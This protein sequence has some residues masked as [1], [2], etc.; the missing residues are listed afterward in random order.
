MVKIGQAKILFDLQYALGNG[1]YILVD[2]DSIHEIYRCD[3]G[4]YYLLAPD[5]L[6]MVLVRKEEFEWL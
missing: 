3:R 6:R 4:C 1:L 2:R 5:K